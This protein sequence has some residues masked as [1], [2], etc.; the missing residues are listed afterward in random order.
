MNIKS[1]IFSIVHQKL[2]ISFDKITTEST[3]ADLGG[4]SLDELEVIMEIERKFDVFL[5]DGV[6]ESMT[7]GQ[8]SESV[9]SLLP[10]EQENEDLP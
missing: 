3:I 1:E 10:S 4:D 5:E 6:Y 7:L 8:L 9:N 2:G